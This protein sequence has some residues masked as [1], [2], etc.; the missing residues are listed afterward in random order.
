[1]KKHVIYYFVLLY[2]FDMLIRGVVQLEKFADG[3]QMIK[4]INTDKKICIGL[5]HEYDLE[6]LIISH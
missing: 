6:S 2:S 4:T 5:G 1:M 3:E